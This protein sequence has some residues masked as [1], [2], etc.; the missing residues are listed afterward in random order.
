MAQILVG[1]DG[2]PA[3]HAALQF[4]V[5]EARLRDAE[6]IAVYVYK[7]VPPDDGS[8]SYRYAR[9]TLDLPGYG[10]EPAGRPDEVSRRATMLKQEE[11]YRRSQAWVEAAEKQA[12]SLV[13]DMIAQVSD[14][15]GDIEVTPRV[16]A[17]AH[18]AE[19]LVDAAA[20]AELLII[21]SRGRGGFKGL[22]LGSVSQQCVQHARCPV[23]V[24]REG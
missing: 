11:D 23:I 20:D 5:E 24:V 7:A 6:L 22:L 2:S 15:E 1:V 12:R 3:A 21:G 4:A 18:P 10:Y 9:D 14:G 19:A 13:E 16:I 8:S 17:D